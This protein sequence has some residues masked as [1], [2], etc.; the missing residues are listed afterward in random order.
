MQ[1][2]EQEAANALNYIEGHKPAIGEGLHL[3][4]LFGGGRV[5]TFQGKT[6][7]YD[8]ETYNSG[9]AAFTD[10]PEYA[11][12]VD[13]ATEVYLDTYP[14]RDRNKSIDRMRRGLSHPRT[15]LMLALHEGN[16]IGFGIFPRLFTSEGPVIYSSR[17]FQGGHDGQGLGTLV[18]GRGIQL[19]Q[20]ESSKA[21]RSLHWGNLMTQN[22][23]SIYTLYKLKEAGIIEKIFPFDYLYDETEEEKKDIDADAAR[24]IMLDMHNRF[25]IDSMGINNVTGVSKA[26][27]RELGPNE[28]YRRAPENPELREIYDR[29]VKSPWN[30]PMNLS[31]H[32]PDGDVVYT[33]F[34]LKKF[35]NGGANSE[36]LETLDE[37]AA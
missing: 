9:R 31:M 34:K 16:A 20:E 6:N 7:L 21:H 23:L 11:G 12:L 29:M 13:L 32:F 14:K 22:E 5:M 24:H 36:I 33:T 18:L 2:V 37:D 17:A 1:A 15:I 28:T 26:E 25:H 27:L 30:N 8:L 19:Q 4:T 10:M 35:G 3:S